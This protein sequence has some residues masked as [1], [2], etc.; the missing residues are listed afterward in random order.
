MGRGLLDGDLDRN[1]K[2]MEIRE[3]LVRLELGRGQIIRSRG[4]WNLTL[5]KRK[6]ILVSRV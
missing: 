5:G 3:D 1:I 4:L 2:V 6:D